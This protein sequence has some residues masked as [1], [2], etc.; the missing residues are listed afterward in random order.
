MYHHLG[1]K[2]T[3]P[4]QD[5]CFHAFFNYSFVIAA[6]ASATAAAIFNR[7]LGRKDTVPVQGKQKSRK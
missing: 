6:L 3:V 7:A 1:R 4:V 5:P 2:D